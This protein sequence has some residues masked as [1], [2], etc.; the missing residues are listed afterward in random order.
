MPLDVFLNVWEQNAKYY[1]VLLGDKG[2][3]A[4]ARKLKNSIKPTI[5]KVL[6]DKPD[7]DL[8]EIDYILEYTLTA[9]IGIMSYWFIKEKTL[10]RESLFSLMHRLMEDGIM[11]HLPL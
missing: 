9:M 4:F 8:R 3:P 7:I 6:E 11:K 5:M 1:S 2:D 10:S